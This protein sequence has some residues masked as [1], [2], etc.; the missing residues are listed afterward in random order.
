MALPD[1]TTTA[2]LRAPCERGQ[3]GPYRPATPRTGGRSRPSAVSPPNAVA[4][5]VTRRDKEPPSC[6]GDGP[7]G[8]EARRAESRR[9]SIT[10]VPTARALILQHNRANPCLTAGGSALQKRA[11]RKGL[12]HALALGL[13]DYGKQ[14]NSPQ[15]RAYV[16][17]ANCCKQVVQEDG[18]VTAHYCRHRGCLVCAAIRTAKLAEAYAPMVV[19]WPEPMFVTLTVPN[20]AGPQLR[21][22]LQEMFA[23]LWECRRA[24]RRQLGPEVRGIAA[25]EV[26]RNGDT[27]LW[28]PHLHIVVDGAAVARAL[29]MEWLKRVPAARLIAQDVRPASKEL[30][31]LLKYPMKPTT[32]RGGKR[33]ALT[34]AELD[35]LFRATHKLR[36]VQPFG[37]VAPAARM[38][39]EITELVA[40]VGAPDNR[41]GRVLW[42]WVPALHDWVDYDTGAVLAGYE[43]TPKQLRALA[44]IAE[45]THPPP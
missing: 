16:R 8:A 38:A 25:R 19:S 2:R 3:A 37:F 12:S 15:L 9:P 24:V 10:T 4:V 44:L 45:A 18:K 17:M 39:E 23:T 13:V 21:R 26:T 11:R 33:A 34:P 5:A 36:M 22:A 29:V 14:V 1:N 35:E 41:Q 7:K 30:R 32:K 42:D 40:T 28:H 31:E 6:G 43:P 20:V 27:Q